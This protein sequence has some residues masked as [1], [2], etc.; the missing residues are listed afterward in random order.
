MLRKRCQCLDS[1]RSSR[2]APLI[3]MSDVFRVA[4]IKAFAIP[5]ATIMPSIAGMALPANSDRAWI[6]ATKPCPKKRFF[7]PQYGTSLW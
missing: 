7:V 6:F 1:H 4:I 5:V 3:A 2:E